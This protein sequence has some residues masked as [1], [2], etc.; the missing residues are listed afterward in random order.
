MLRGRARDCGFR[1]A[2]AAASDLLPLTERLKASLSP[3]DRQSLKVVAEE[4]VGRGLVSS[5]GL[6]MSRL[7]ELAFSFDRNLPQRLECLQR[8]EDV[9]IRAT[10]EAYHEL[11]VATESAKGVLEAERVALEMIDAGLEP[12][13]ETWHLLVAKQDSPADRQRVLQ[14]MLASRARPDKEIFGYL[15]GKDRT[16]EVALQEVQNAGGTINLYTCNA[17]LD[18]LAET[19][20]PGAVEDLL[21]FMKEVKLRPSQYSYHALIAAQARSGSSDGAMRVLEMMSTDGLSPMAETYNCL[22]KNMALAGDFQGAR[23]AVDGMDDVKGL[24]PNTETFNGILEGLSQHQDAQG[25]RDVLELM[26]QRAVDAGLQ[27]FDAVQ[28]V[29]QPDSK[30]TAGELDE[31]LAELEAK[32]VPIMR[33]VW[34]HCM[35]TGFGAGGDGLKDTLLGMY[36]RMQVAAGDRPDRIT[37]NIVLEWLSRNGHEEDA[38][39]VV[40]D[41]LHSGR[42]RPSSYTLR[43]LEK[44]PNLKRRTEEE[45]ASRLAKREQDDRDEWQRRGWRAQR[46]AT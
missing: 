8:F 35:L 44:F 38:D 34:H 11:V 21:A 4:L 22:A 28:R 37:Y 33:E 23:R 25:T 24:I 39:R 31:V 19:R 18:A 2:R 16:F 36:K 20:A 3:V 9:G 32:N 42:L 40:Q 12:L 17:L 13:R 1:V 10:P 26:G 14:A 5:S 41:M 43:T 6:R 29:L 7:V 27:T 30:N 46:L 15:L 45:V